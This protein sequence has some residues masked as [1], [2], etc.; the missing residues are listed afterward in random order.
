MTTATCRVKLNRTTQE[1]DVTSPSGTTIIVPVERLSG[2]LRILANP[3]HAAI[4]RTVQLT[5][6]DMRF[7]LANAD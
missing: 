1:I 3:A 5:C 6:A 2:E 7:L 4:H